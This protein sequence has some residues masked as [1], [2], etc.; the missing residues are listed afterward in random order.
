MLEKK[1]KDYIIKNYGDKYSNPTNYT[2]NSKNAQ[3]AHEAI[4]PTKLEVSNITNMSPECVKLYNLIWKRTIA[5][6]MSPAEILTK[7]LSIDAVNYPKMKSILPKK[8]FFKPIETILFDGFL[9]VYNN[10]IQIEGVE[11]T[12]SQNDCEINS[13]KKIKLKVGDKV[14][15]K[16]ISVSE[17]YTKP[18]LRYNE[19]GLIKYLEKMVSEDH[20]HMLA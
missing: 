14:K 12:D 8:I 9:I 18:P 20:L 16:S 11:D 7:H 2:K 15:F 3:E 6:Q 13:E 19:A 4:R 1:A 10:K 17:E 5:S